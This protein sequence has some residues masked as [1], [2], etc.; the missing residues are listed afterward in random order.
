MPDIKLKTN[1]ETLA[2]NLP[3]SVEEICKAIDPT[4]RGKSP[5]I[6]GILGEAFHRCKIHL[7]SNT[8]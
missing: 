3:I 5:V 4:K 1:V 7:G 6:D 8:E 2:W